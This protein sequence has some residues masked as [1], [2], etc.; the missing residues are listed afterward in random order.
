M[1]VRQVKCIPLIPIR[2]GTSSVKIEKA[3][4]MNMKCIGVRPSGVKTY[5]DISK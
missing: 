3:K 1:K 4:N 2:E 5:A